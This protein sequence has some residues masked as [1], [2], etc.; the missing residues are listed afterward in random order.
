M[1]ADEVYIE[2]RNFSE[3]FS[4]MLKEETHP[5]RDVSLPALVT[6]GTIGTSRRRGVMVDVGV[7]ASTG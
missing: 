5:R 4:L 7:F 3:G 6:S 2:C 1:P